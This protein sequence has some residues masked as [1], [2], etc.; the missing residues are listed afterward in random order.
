MMDGRCCLL[1]M[2]ETLPDATLR[3]AAPSR[4]ATHL[5]EGLIYLSRDQ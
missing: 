5:G 3:N 2:L 4:V 1:F